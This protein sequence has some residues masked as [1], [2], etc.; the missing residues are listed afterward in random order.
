MSGYDNPAETTVGNRRYLLEELIGRGRYASVFRAVDTWA[1]SEWAVKLIKAGES[2]HAGEFDFAA[3]L[4]Y[5]GIVSP[6]HCGET[7]DGGAGVVFP[8][9]RG[10]P[11]TRFFRETPPGD[12]AALFRMLARELLENTRYLHDRDLLHLDL[13]PDHLLVDI[14]PLIRPREPNTQGKSTAPRPSVY[15][16]DLGSLCFVR[17][18][19][20]AEGARGT[21]AYMAPEWR[22]GRKADQRTDIYSLGVILREIL[23][24]TVFYGDAGPGDPD[25]PLRAGLTGRSATRFGKTL[26]SMISS[27]PSSRPWNIDEIVE[28]LSLEQDL[29]PFLREEAPFKSRFTGRRREIELF[30][31]RIGELHRSGKG[32]VALVLGGKGSGKSRFLREIEFAARA[33]FETDWMIAPP[34]IFDGGTA[35][36]VKKRQADENAPLVVVIDDCTGFEIEALAVLRGKPVLVVASAAGSADFGAGDVAVG[37]PGDVPADAAPDRPEDFAVNGE[38]DRGEAAPGGSFP[39]GAP[40]DCLDIRLHP[41]AASAVSELLAPFMPGKENRSRLAELIT[42][43]S[44]GNCSRFHAVAGEFRDGVISISPARMIRRILGESGNITLYDASMRQLR[45]SLSAS[46]RKNARWCARTAAKLCRSRCKK[47]GLHLLGATLSSLDGDFERALLHLRK[48]VSH[49]RERPSPAAAAHGGVLAVEALVRMGRFEEAETEARRMLHRRDDLPGETETILCTAL[50][51][52]ILERRGRLEEGRRLLE[53]A[54][55]STVAA[56]PVARRGKAEAARLSALGAIY[57]KLGE[58]D[59]AAAVFAGAFSLLGMPRNFREASFPVPERAASGVLGVL[60]SCINNYG[61]LLWKKGDLH[62]AEKA[63]SK[64]L[65]LRERQGDILFAASAADNLAAVSYRLGAVKRGLDLFHYAL[66]RRLDA[67]DMRGA[68]NSLNNIGVVHQDAERWVLALRTHREALAVRRRI[69][70]REGMAVSTHNLGLLERKRGRYE[71]AL[72]YYSES[73]VLKEELADKAGIVRTRCNRA[74]L[75]LAGGDLEKAAGDVS[76]VVPLAGELDSPELDTLTRHVQALLLREQG[77]STSAAALFESIR[78]L[79]GDPA[80]SG[81]GERML[82]CSIDHAETLTELGR[83]PEAVGILGGI[84]DAIRSLGDR[85]LLLSFNRVSAVAALEENRRD[86]CRE[87]CINAARLVADS[88]CDPLEEAKLAIL[89]GRLAA[90]E[91][92]FDSASRAFR[93][94]GELAR[95]LGNERLAAQIPTEPAS[96]PTDGAGPPAHRPGT[97]LPDARIS[98]NTPEYQKNDASKRKDDAKMGRELLNALARTRVIYEGSLAAVREMTEA[99]NSMMEPEELL[100]KLLDLMMGTVGGE[101]GVILLDDD[102]D[103]DDGGDFRVAATKGMDPLTVADAKEY[104]RTIVSRAFNEE[105]FIFS[106]NAAEDEDFAGHLSVSRLG[107]VSFMCCPLVRRGK[108]IGTVYVDNRSE[109][110]SFGN[111]DRDILR[112][113]A[114]LAAVAIDNAVRAA[115]IRRENRR[116][117]KVVAEETSFP[118]I[119]GAS[120][121]MRRLFSI[122]ER[123]LD[124]DIP[125]LIQGE[126]GSGKELVARAL[127][128]QGRRKDKP[129]V[130]VDCG[131]LH[132]NLVESE[133]F[134]H[135]KGAFS[136]AVTRRKGLFEEADGGSIFLDEI[137]N[138]GVRLQAKLLRVL[139]EGEFRRVGET[140]IRRTDVRVICATNRDLRVDVAAGRF[141]EDLYYRI[142]IVALDLPPLRER[143]EDIPLL[144]EHL[145]AKIEKKYGL[146]FPS[147]THRAMKALIGCD[148]PGNVRQL[149]NMLAGLPVLC[150]DGIADIDLLPM[151][152][153]PGKG[154][155]SREPGED[156]GSGVPDGSRSAGGRDI[157]DE[158]ASFHPGT[159]DFSGYD[160]TLED[161]ERRDIRA[162][163]EKAGWVQTRTALLLGVSERSLRYKMAKYDIEN[164]RLKE[165]RKRRRS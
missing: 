128:Y 34:G 23:E 47:A 91:E 105:R 68:A 135:E 81:G 123:L 45:L 82:Q 113:F 133:L 18:N 30:L 142:R 147:I 145:S 138:L 115:D 99:L 148:W 150:P 137:S 38:R 130:A 87:L 76:A 74:V 151:E 102:D 90:L 162:A 88:P 54:A 61:V 75:Y 42:R 20:H 7:G 33:T 72:D 36:L 57:T 2:A 19:P 29:T 65:L 110:D 92:R 9:I 32:G 6:Q 13:K 55:D 116:L 84:A 127:H 15:L 67:D 96:A 80:A 48:Y 10:V 114:N 141:R 43:E 100:A 12:S 95:D 118:R 77:D 131:I 120:P 103:G 49:A 89:V 5:P 14:D 101:R 35:D 85:R 31:G 1:G 17:E 58:N 139:Q 66:S 134:G 132:E 97:A 70:D 63:F 21:P 160:L 144:V 106:A 22:S 53:E 16:I 161:R 154:G 11:L 111:K 117:K 86:D 78:P 8:L 98:D 136:G 104:S 156:P 165:R 44:G 24:A 52:R 51:G 124:N 50:L 25:L 73:L 83:N 159:Q 79:P 64:A 157:Q 41:P 146:P 71:A 125:V 140:R 109:I 3:R 28:G 108:T 153:A 119:I 27:D 152:T 93:R 107:I 26:D 69:D 122:M 4:D 149:E 94:A 129:F 112:T 46:D 59:K 143:V 60:A 37:V 158:S 155:F 163:L 56:C 164:I 121:A 62:G 126:T 39:A 40:A